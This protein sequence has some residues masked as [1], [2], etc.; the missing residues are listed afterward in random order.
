MS[1]LGAGLRGLRRPAGLRLIALAALISGLAG[2]GWGLGGEPEY[3]AAASA[4]VVDRG[5]AVERIGGGSTGDGGPASGARLLELARSRE[6]AEL[7]AGD[8][9]G[10]VSGADLLA[11]TG[12]SFT[13]DDAVLVVRSTAE[14]GDF[15]AAAAN[16]YQGA[17]VE[18]S[19]ILERRRLN[20]G[21]ERLQERLDDLEPGSEEA[22][23]V[24]A[25]I[26]DVEDLLAAGP[27]LRAGGDAT[28]PE[29]PISSRPTLAVTAIAAVLGALLAASVLLVA[30]VLRRPPSAGDAFAA[31]LDGPVLATFGREEIARRSDPGTVELDSAAGAELAGLLDRIGLTTG[32]TAP[33]SLA[34]TGASP[35]QGRRSLALGIAAT[36]A[37]RDL[38]VIL[39]E[40]DLHSPGLDRA[41]GVP[42]APGL[43][44]YL[45]GEASPREVMRSIRVRNNGGDADNPSF[46]VVTAG[47]GPGADTPAPNEPQLER[48]ITQ[49]ERAYDLIIFDA[50]PLLG[51]SEEPLVTAAA[52][53]TIL[54]VRGGEASIDELSAVL[55]RLE[56]SELLGGVLLGAEEPAPTAL[57]DGLDGAET[58][59]DQP[60]ESSSPP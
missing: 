20:R 44:E 53:A 29:D 2:L 5:E 4:V 39:V 15:A 34:I 41:L 1:R 3:R 42:A 52:E 60:A 9:G 46:V 14:F 18:L 54:A 56:G 22:I 11:R 47:A 8:L 33:R 13:D 28:L 30:G 57:E 27:P 24:E 48:L 21:A 7:A 31:V 10:D 38:S 58:G 50:S 45:A 37:L 12:F 40:A 49:L 23:R 35:D 51:V 25:R 16:A 59:A 17:I 43:S 19:S 36:A 32:G 55:A 26:G 6:V